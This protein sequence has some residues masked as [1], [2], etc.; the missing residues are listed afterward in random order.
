MYPTSARIETAAVCLRCSRA[1]DLARTMT[2]SDRVVHVQRGLRLMRCCACAD[3]YAPWGGGPN[4]GAALKTATGW[5]N[6]VVG[7]CRAHNIFHVC[8]TKE[9]TE[10]SATCQDKAV[11]FVCA[12]LDDTDV[13]L[14][15]SPLRRILVIPPYASALDSVSTPALRCNSAILR[16]DFGRYWC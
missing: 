2:S 1:L 8:G 6:V 10:S 11:S 7:G 4:T 16:A 15:A 9:G 13:S 3:I 14:G 5:D 12:K